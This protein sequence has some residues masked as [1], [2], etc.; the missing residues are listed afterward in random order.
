GFSGGAL[1]TGHIVID[2]N[3]PKCS[4]GRHGCVEAFAS[5]P[6]MLE[7][8]NT[9]SGDN[10]SNIVEFREKLDKKNPYALKVIEKEAFYISVLISNLVNTL[11]PS[12]V[13]IGGEIEILEDYLMPII[14]EKVKR[15]CLITNRSTLEI[16]GSIL[17]DIAASYGA[18]V[19]AMEEIIETSPF[20]EN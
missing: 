15:D 18:A 4:C 1:E 12:H 7:T 9:I 5:V 16:K 2:F 17:K 6:A 20:E 13:I 8:Y 14:I 10:L 11:N 19:L 3:G